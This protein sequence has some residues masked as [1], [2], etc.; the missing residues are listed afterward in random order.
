MKVIDKNID[1]IT[2]NCSQSNKSTMVIN[3]TNCPVGDSIEIKGYPCEQ[4]IFKERLDGLAEHFR[5]KFNTDPELYVRV[6]GRVNLIG[7]HV[8]Y[9][10]YSVCPMAI[11]RDICIAASTLSGDGEF[12]KVTNLQSQ[13][14][15]ST[16]SS[17]DFRYSFNFY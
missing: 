16:I 7:E 5:S 13:Y 3:S 1:S 2:L 11:N 9:C 17:K 12:L 10:G 4:N 15:D 14:E 6:P 8:D